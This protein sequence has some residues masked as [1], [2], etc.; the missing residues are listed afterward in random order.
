M[1]LHDPVQRVA[2]MAKGKDK[3]KQATDAELFT[4]DEAGDEGLRRSLYASTWDAPAAAHP[5][6]GSGKP[7]KSEQILAQRSRVPAR[8]SKATPGVMVQ[9]KLEREKRSKITP[10]VKKRLRG[11]VKRNEMHDRGLWD[12]SDAQKQVGLL[13]G[14]NVPTGGYDAWGASTSAVTLPRVTEDIKELVTKRIPKVGNT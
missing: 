4:V 13:N 2:T 1:I 6:K 14:E 7:L 10:E 8:T 9:Q 3:M 11:M 5:R 12:V